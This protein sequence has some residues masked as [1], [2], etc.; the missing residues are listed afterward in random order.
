MYL[1]AMER[2]AAHRPQ[3]LKED[4]VSRDLDY[5][6]SPFPHLLLAVAFVF[7]FQKLIDKNCNW[8]FWMQVDGRPYFISGFNNYAMVTRAAD[9]MPGRYTRHADV[10]GTFM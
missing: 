8:N 4:P 10:E 2:A 7:A 6:P 5:V 3:S 1:S 9:P